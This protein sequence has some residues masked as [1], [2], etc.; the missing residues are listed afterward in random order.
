MRT[1][2]SSIGIYN[3]HLSKVLV[4]FL[5]LIISI[6][7]CAKDSFMFYKKIKK[8]NAA[9]RFLISYDTFNLF[10]NILLKETIYIA[11]NLLFEYNPGLKIT[12]A[13]EKKNFFWIYN[14]LFT[15][16]FSRYIL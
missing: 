8:V 1:I 13:E 12:K 10:A 3:Y 4:D 2:V 7:H 15:I 14:I 16:S 5:D 11:V 6:S 9:N